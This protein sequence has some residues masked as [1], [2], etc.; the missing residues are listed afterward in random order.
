[1]LL[2]VKETSKLKSNLRNSSHIVVEAGMYS[3]I[4]R[5]ESHNCIKVNFLLA[6]GLIN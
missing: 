3:R 4:S 6:I 5:A 2:L 1:M